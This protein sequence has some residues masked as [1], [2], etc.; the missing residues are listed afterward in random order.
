MGLILQIFKG[1]LR[2]LHPTHPVLAGYGYQVR[3]GSGL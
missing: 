1:R 2:S 3:I